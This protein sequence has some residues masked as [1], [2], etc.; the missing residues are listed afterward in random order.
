MINDINISFES[1]VWIQMQE[2]QIVSFEIIY[3]K[4]LIGTTIRNFK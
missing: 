2:D 3:N 4:Y 1:I